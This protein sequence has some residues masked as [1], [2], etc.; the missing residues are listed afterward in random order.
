MVSRHSAILA[1]QP[2]PQP[3]NMSLLGHP[4]IV[5]TFRFAGGVCRR[6]TTEGSPRPSEGEVRRRRTEARS[7]A[8]GNAGPVYPQARPAC[9]NQSAMRFTSGRATRTQPNG[10]THPVRSIVEIPEKSRTPKG[11]FGTPNV[12]F[13]DTRT[14]QP[15]QDTQ[16]LDSGHT[17][18]GFKTLG[19][20]GQFCPPNHRLN[21]KIC[22]CLDTQQSSQR[23]DSREE[24][25]VGRRLSVALAPRGVGKEESHM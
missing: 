25:A 16:R 4:T 21:R 6:Q 19:N 18:F 17:R 15:V 10:Y 7:V 5:P 8:G 1:P 3:E 23:S 9:E 13:R 11:Q 14:V 24:S 2:P 22:R 12:W 20:S